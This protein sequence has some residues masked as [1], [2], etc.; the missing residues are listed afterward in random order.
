MKDKIEIMPVGT[1]SP[2]CKG[3]HNCPGFLIKYKDKRILLDCGNGI[4]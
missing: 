3:K 2:Y 4:S 1:V